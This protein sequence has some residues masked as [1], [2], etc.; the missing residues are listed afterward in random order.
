MS[1]KAAQQTIFSVIKSVL[2]RPRGGCHNTSEELMAASATAPGPEAHR[3][4]C[5]DVTD[6]EFSTGENIPGLSG[7]DIE[8]QEAINRSLSNAH[9]ERRCLGK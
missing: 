8:S 2:S 9:T 5:K 6:D 1:D 3:L 7:R 4:P